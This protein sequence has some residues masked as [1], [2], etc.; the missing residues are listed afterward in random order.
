M[1][2]TKKHVEDEISKLHSLMTLEFGVSKPS[3]TS[4]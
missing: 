4:L 2:A 1:I 3:T